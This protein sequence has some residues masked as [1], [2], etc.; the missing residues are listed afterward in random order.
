MDVPQPREEE[1]PDPPRASRSSGAGRVFASTATLCAPWIQSVRRAL[2]AAGPAAERALSA[3]EDEIARVPS[4]VRRRA[5]RT[6]LGQDRPGLLRKGN[7]V[8]PVDFSSALPEG[9]SQLHEGS[10]TARYGVSLLT[11]AK[12]PKLGRLDISHFLHV[13]FFR[14]PSISLTTVISI[15]RNSDQPKAA[16]SFSR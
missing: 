10:A 6:D 9:Q 1:L 12:V 7:D 2:L 11:K 5:P 16:I 4:F 13:I 8:R 15:S 14:S 3:P